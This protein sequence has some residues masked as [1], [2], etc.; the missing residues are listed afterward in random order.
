MSASPI[1]DVS[2]AKS[3]NALLGRA[4][5]AICDFLQVDKTI[6]K[7]NVLRKISSRQLKTTG[8][9]SLQVGKKKSAIA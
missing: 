1:C 7:K 6:V 5:L 3:A 8:S 4:E 9:T 2:F